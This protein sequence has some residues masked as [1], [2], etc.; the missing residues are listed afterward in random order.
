MQFSSATQTHTYTQSLNHRQT[1]GQVLHGCGTL[2]H[3]RR[4][5]PQIQRNVDKNVPLTRMSPVQNAF[6]F[7][8]TYVTHTFDDERKLWACLCVSTGR[9][10]VFISHV[11]FYRLYKGFISQAIS[12]RHVPTITNPTFLNQWYTATDEVSITSGNLNPPKKT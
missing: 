4:L 1:T 3:C 7:T 5:I 12:L 11:L 2:V 8:H 9:L 6:G 10:S